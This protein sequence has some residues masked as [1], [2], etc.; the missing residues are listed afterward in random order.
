MNSFLHIDYETASEV[1]LGGGKGSVGLHNYSTHSSTRV[2][3]LAWAYGDERVELWQPHSETMPE[4]LRRG[5][6]DQSQLLAAWNASF[7][8]YISNNVLKLN[9]D[10]QRF[11]DPQ[12]SAR[13]LSLP[14]SLDDVG[15]ILD[16]PAA[17]RKDRRGEEL[18]NLFSKMTKKKKKRGEPVEY[19]FCNWDTNPDEWQEF[20]EYCRQDVITEREIMRRLEILQVFPLPERERRIWI[21]DQTVNDRGM[22]VDV[23]FVT[24]AYALASREKDEKIKE[25]NTLTG[26]AN[27]NS[28]SQMLAWVKTQGYKTGSLRKEAVQAELD[29]NTDLTELARQA[30]LIRKSAS[31]TTYKKLSAIL[32][33]VSADARL[34]N[35][36]LYMGSARCGRWSGNAVQLHNMARPTKVFEDLR[37]VDKLRAMVYADDYAGIK[38]TFDSVLLAV[39]SCIRTAFVAKPGNSL[40]VS[41]LNAIETRVAAWVCECQPLLNVFLQNKCPYI[42]FASKMT[43]IPYEVLYRDYMSADATLKAIAKKHRQDAKPGVLGCVY[44][45]SGGQLGKNKHGDVIK[46][47]LWGYAAN[48]GIDLSRERCHEIVGI[49]RDVYDDIPKFWV[50]AE[51][52]VMDVLEGGSRATRKLGPNGCIVIDKIIIKDRGAV[53]RIKLPSGR[54]LHYIDA[55]TELVKMPWQD[56]NGNDVWKRGFVYAGINQETKQW[57][58][59]NSHGGKILENIVQGIARDVLAESLL[60]F[61]QQLAMPV[62]GHVHDEGIVEDTDDLLAFGVSTMESVMGQPI[63][64]A[65]GLP[66]KAEGFESTYYHK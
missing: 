46:Q 66:L 20:C 48:M 29:F 5:L 12:A 38:T 49:F 1:Q 60:V 39:K 14:G 57:Q 56:R 63:A 36:F 16:L 4:A 54:Y 8:R 15:V 19:Q 41:D 3:M 52:A 10:I 59:V 28:N 31:S 53:M 2:L 64:W 9:L 65:P 47:G 21:F 25:N 30:L 50:I 34:R 32:R 6:E 44:R 51:Q 22:P 17:L 45:L 23:E 33:Q 42:D 26:L 18:V 27:S 7:E 58:K 55:H 35:Q 40:R 13:Y 37:N 43:G 62:V 24:K 11:H 61:E